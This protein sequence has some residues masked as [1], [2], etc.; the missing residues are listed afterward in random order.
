MELPFYDR[1]IIQLAAERCGFSAQFM[2]KLEEQPS[3]QLFYAG[4]AGH[5]QMQESL[6]PMSPQDKIFLAQFQVIR[7]A[8]DKGPCVIIGRCADYILR[9]HPNAIHIFIHASLANR[10]KRAV[11]YYGLTSDTAEKTIL[12]T[13]KKRA[14]YHERYTDTRWGAAANYHLCIDSGAIGIENSVE[15]I[16]R[17]AEM[18]SAAL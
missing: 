2:E 14:L 17:F 10:V 9:N 3:G 1:E 11:Q 4:P 5:L 6:P 15:L 8:A 12:K 13:D 7:E 18:R 16:R